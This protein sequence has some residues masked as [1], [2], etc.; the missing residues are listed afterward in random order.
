MHPVE[1]EN[2]AFRYPEARGGIFQGLSLCM[3][4]GI[5][6]LIGQNGSGK[7]T[8]L[9]LAAGN[10]LPTAG[11]V[12]INGIDTRELRDEQERQRHVSLI[13]Q[14]MEFETEEPVGDLLEY[15][16]HG[17]FIE[18]KDPEFLRRLTAA[19][20]LEKFLH[21][22]T[23][24]ISKGELQRTILAFSLLY[25]SKILLMDEPIFALEA[26]QKER[27][28]EFLVSYTR[29]NGIILYYSVHELDITEKYCD[30]ILLFSKKKPPLLGMKDRIYTRDTIENAYEYPF[31]L[32]KK[33]EAVYRAMLNEAS[34]AYRG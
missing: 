23:Q 16:Y 22:R 34:A 17:G 8:F 30:Y 25:G 7:S 10:L 13:F 4:E 3:P 18:S 19:F 5:V 6:S 28:M 32:L 9:L 15:V 24:E 21:K 33:K 27:A 14:N 29:S 20:E 11:T 26:Y 12:R 31:A 1:L 2:V